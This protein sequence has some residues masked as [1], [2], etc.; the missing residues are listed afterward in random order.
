[1]REFFGRVGPPDMNILSNF[2]VLTKILAV[3]GVMA[4]VA[5]TITFFGTRSLS[6]LNDATNI[7]ETKAGGALL[8]ARISR[9]VVSLNRAEYVLAS[10]PT[11]ET[12][13]KIRSEVDEELKA[14]AERLTSLK[15]SV[16][17]ED[18]KHVVEIETA[19]AS[20]SKELE[21]TFRVAD[22]IRDFT[23][24][25]DMKKLQDSVASSS[26]ATNNLRTA[27]HAL[28]TA[29]DKEVSVVS[30]AATEEYEHASRLMF[31]V[32][33]VGI[34]FGLAMGFIISQFGIVKPLRAMVDVL[35]KLAGGDYHVEIVGQDRKD[36]VG[37]V[38]KTAVVFKDNALEKIRLEEE[39]KLAE[40]R[41]SD[42]RKTDMHR[43][44]DDFQRAVGG[45]VEMVSN[46]SSQLEGAATSL[47]QTAELTQE[48]SGVVAAASEE[49][50]AN[51]QG[52]AAASEQLASTVT[53]IGRQV[54]ESSNIAT[55]AVHQAAKTN[56]QV[57]Q[58][59]ET[60]NRIGDVVGL[61]TTIAAQTNL[62]ALNAT[63]EAARAG[64]A[65]KGF[66]VVAQEVKA[67]AAQTAKATNEIAAQISGMQTATQE[68]VGAIHDITTTINK[69]SEISGAI[70]AAVEEQAATTQEISRNVTEAAKGTS[71]VAMSITDVSKGASDTGT[72]SSQVLSSA[73]QL[74][75]ESRSLRD[76]VDTFL[77]TVRAA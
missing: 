71:E 30:A 45:I 72:A 40:K 43:L 8:A 64:D 18:E 70:A 50:S 31:I 36:E 58:L 55:Q 13:A 59:S 35:Q 73:K 42:Q 19:F 4:L 37:D 32:A 41:A 49:T 15:K 1:M 16:S 39:Q 10:N 62:L 34:L 25:E 53:E 24:T 68:A 63:I 5:I 29:L 76:Q 7:M 57:N 12:R 21:D 3:I 75:S 11:P 27:V 28:Q 17:Q 46:A 60:A 54:Q 61:I 2:K 6:N 44:A 22:Q 69:M 56:D 26:V 52:V 23:A 38:A 67:L 48:R 47:T 74:S 65:G 9:V 77:R 20:Y 33:T 14:F 51:V 66:A